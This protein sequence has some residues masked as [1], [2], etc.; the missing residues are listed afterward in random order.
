MKQNRQL[1]LRRY[2]VG[3]VR[4]KICGITR[5][6]DALWAERLGVSALG[7]NLVPGTRRYRPAEH[8]RSMATQLGPL[9][10]CVGIFQNLEPEQVLAQMQTAG[11]QVAQL[12]GDEPHEWAE[13]VGQHYPVI[14]AIN[15]SGLADPKWL[16]YPAQALLVD[17]RSPGSGETYPLEWLEPLRS[18]PHLIIAGGLTPENLDPVLA[19]NPYGVDVSSGVEMAPGE[20]DPH[21]VQ[22]F[23]EVVQQAN[24]G[25]PQPS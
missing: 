19:L 6:E 3:V 9:I 25:Y 1:G 18:H 13:Q 2:T 12:H 15:L 5:L 16:D 20:K 14:K 17:A 11:L 21:K 23:L 7:F 4:A 22:R 24:R 10:Q 8:A